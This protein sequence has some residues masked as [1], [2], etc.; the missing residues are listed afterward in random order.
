M[1]DD[2][3]GDGSII[4][5]TSLT[6]RVPLSEVCIRQ[7]IVAGSGVGGTHSNR[8][9][10]PL[11]GSGVNML[12]SRQ[13]MGEWFACRL[14]VIIGRLASC[15][16]VGKSCSSL[17]GAMWRRLV[18]TKDEVICG[19]HPKAMSRSFARL[20]QSRCT[21]QFG[22]VSSRRPHV[23]REQRAVAH[24][25]VLGAWAPILCASRLDVNN[26]LFASRLVCTERLA[27]TW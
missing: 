11:V 16:K 25:T 6:R 22:H 19:T 13:R 24:K 23:V 2:C 12:H 8:F 20:S 1:A 18:V 7:M 5:H 3:S 10:I 9:A 21:S 4:A 26:W 17:L 14:V 27:S 15:Q